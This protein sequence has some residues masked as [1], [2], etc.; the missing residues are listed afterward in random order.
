MTKYIIS[1]VIIAAFLLCGCSTDSSISMGDNSSSSNKKP[2]KKPDPE[3]EELDE[4]GNPVKESCKKADLMTSLYHCGACNN[5]CGANE[6][7][8][9][10]KCECGSEFELCGSKCVPEGKCECT[11]D[12]TMDCYDGP[13]GTENIG[14]CRGGVIRCLFDP[15]MGCYWDSQCSDQVMPDYEYHCDPSKPLKDA[16]C[17]GVP[18]S[19]QDDDND[20]FPICGTDSKKLLDCC[21]NTNMCNTSKPDFVNSG[22]TVDCKGNNIDDDCD[23][24]IDED[25]VDCASSTGSPESCAF[26][27]ESCSEVSDYKQ[28]NSAAPADTAYALAKAIDICTGKVSAGSNQPGI[29]EASLFSMHTSNSGGFGFQSGGCARPNDTFDLVSGVQVNIKDSMK[30]ISGESLISPRS[31]KTFIILSSGRA[32]DA[33]SKVGTSDV[34]ISSGGK[35]PEPYCSKHAQRLESHKGC[36][37]SSKMNDSVHL[38]LRLKAPEYAQGFSFDFRFFTREYP[39]YICTS[40]NDFF[41]T[42][43]TDEKGQPFVDTNDDNQINDED[44]NISYDKAGNPVSVNNA[45]FTTCASPRCHDYQAMKS[46]SKNGC[47]PIIEACTDNK[48]GSCDDGPDALS[49]YYP[50]PYLGSGDGTVARGGGTAWLTTKAPVNPGQVFN[51][52]FY[53]WD[54][55]DQIFDSTVLIDNFQWLCSKPGVGTDFAPPIDGIN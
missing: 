12:E 23:G 20:G 32:N 47:P 4:F 2:G 50:N 36:G 25:D 44:G 18:D 43:L 41:L 21:D 39:Y 7:C 55:E 1:S 54:T 48:C 29:I 15:E 22:K 42:L 52:D 26:P 24:Q 51:L 19:Q 13:I 10:G 14:E 38:H 30:S 16:D 49:A 34:S 3:E 8:K 5:E 6:I 33:Y 9:S 53:I 35:I 27:R 37:G 31:G 46:V 28:S 40:F 17:N 11:P 45:F